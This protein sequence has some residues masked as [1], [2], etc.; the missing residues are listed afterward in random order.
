MTTGIVSGIGRSLPISLG[1]GT[2]L[3]AAYVN[4]LIKNSPADKAG[5]HGSTI[6]QYGTKHLV[7]IIIA[8]DGHNI[9]K[10]DDLV[11]YIGEHKSV[12]YKI[13]YL[14]A[15]QVAAEINLAFLTFQKLE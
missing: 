11:N 3:E 9:T 5:I 1:A 13:A 4:T 12:G 6:D 7:D 14:L 15:L 2:N 10:S 8:A